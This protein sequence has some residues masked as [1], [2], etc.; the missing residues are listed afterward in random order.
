[1]EVFFEWGGGVFCDVLEMFT[2]CARVRGKVYIIRFHCN[3]LRNGTK[4]KGLK[5]KFKIRNTNI[6]V[7]M[8][9]IFYFQNLLGY[10]DVEKCE[11]VEE[12]GK[13]R[14]WKENGDY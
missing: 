12:N 2:E 11:A 13:R 6:A 7:L 8:R 10:F 9:I 1:M 3:L 4:K 5:H 14:E